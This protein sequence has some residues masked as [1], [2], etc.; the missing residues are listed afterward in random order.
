MSLPPAVLQVLLLVVTVVAAYF[1]LRW[2]RIPNWLTVT[3]VLGGLVLNALL[4]EWSGLRLSVLGAG[5]ALLVYVP[6]FAL[7]AMG[8]GDLKMMA[9]VGA[10]TGPT[11]WFAIF[12]VTSI[13]GGIIAVVTILL[14]GRVGRTFSNLG[15]VLWELAH[16]RRPYKGREELD[17]AHPKS[18]SLPHGAVIAL[19]C[20]V[21]LLLART[22]AT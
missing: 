14:K 9:A 5:L 4:L 21:F 22:A 7:R 2:R 8:G 10:I 16:L 13:L 12:I 18:M 11:N 20:V 19:G 17:I 3:G 1:D 15:F 6:L